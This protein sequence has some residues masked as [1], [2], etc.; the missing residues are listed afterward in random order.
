MNR[1]QQGDDGLGGVKE[2]LQRIQRLSAQ[3]DNAEVQ[4][5]KKDSSRCI[6]I[7]AVSAAAAIVLSVAGAFLLL[8]SSRPTHTV[9]V[10]TVPQLRVHDMGRADAPPLAAHDK[11]RAERLLRGEEYLANGSVIS[12]RAFFERAA[13]AGLA[14]GA[15]RLA[16]TYDPGELQRLQALRVVPDPALARRWYE[17]AREL[18]APDAVEQLARLSGN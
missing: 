10:L 18:G 1:P 6:A 4:T 14:A 13:A 15:L 9:M 16:A 7:A 12:A 11:A 3:P 17:R 5:A 8:S 2:V